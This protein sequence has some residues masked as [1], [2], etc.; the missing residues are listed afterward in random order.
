MS[1][2]DEPNPPADEALPAELA[3]VWQLEAQ[4]PGLRAG[5]RHDLAVALGERLL[6]LC[7]AA[8]GPAHPKTLGTL[9]QLGESYFQIS[10][11][12]RAEALF[13]RVLAEREAAAPPDPAALGLALTQLAKLRRKTGALDRAEALYR[14]ALDV[15]QAAPPSALLGAATALHGLALLLEDRGQL[16]DAEAACRAA[17]DTR[18]K[19][20][21]GD[22]LPVAES[23]NALAVLR[24]KQGDLDGAEKLYLRALAIHEAKQGA[25]HPELATMLTNLGILY[26]EKREHERAGEALA[27]AAALLEA[28]G[29]PDDVWTAG[30]F[31]ALGTHREA[32]GDDA[33]A[34]AAARRALA[35]REEVLGPSHPDVALSL[36]NVAGKL[37]AAEATRPEAEALLRRALGLLGERVTPSLGQILLNLS[38]LRAAADDLDEAEAL[39]TRALTLAKETAGADHP[40]AAKALHE[41][42]VLAERRGD[43]DEALDLMRRVL[44]IRT[45]RPTL[46][47]GIADMTRMGELLLAANLPD[48]AEPFLKDALELAAGSRGQDDPSVAHLIFLAGKLAMARED[49]KHALFC[50]GQALSIEE[51]AKGRTHPDLLELLALSAD[52]NLALGKLGAAEAAYRRVGAIYAASY[53]PDSEWQAIAPL[54]LGEVAMKRKAYAKAAEL[55]ERALGLAEAAFGEDDLRLQVVLDRAAEARLS[56]GDLARAEE[57]SRRLLV[58]YERELGPGAAPLLPAVRRLATIYMK[59]DDPRVAE[60]LERT[61]AC[62]RAATRDL[63]AETAAL[64]AKRTRGSS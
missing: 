46:D 6:E 60:M 49:P 25:A 44:V 13:E 40:D 39:A 42:S 15:Y 47:Q 38:L 21:G 64:N 27:R 18:E 48:P 8:L 32:M 23:V 26:T 55:F 33:G 20:L 61:T 17:L 57:L 22:A 9:E 53:P 29:G 51:K 62:L 3:E 1:T 37:T 52:A 36:N 35:I 58:M 7:E 34:L 50:V 43:L 2:P 19:V 4:L 28:R 24:R 56:N 11:Y 45:K 10:R 5:G 41:L 63:E 14:R 59:T 12:E 30:L 54:Q 16:D 31:D